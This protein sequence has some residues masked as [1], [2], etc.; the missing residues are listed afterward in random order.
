MVAAHRPCIHR[1]ICTVKP[2]Q[3]F[4]QL[5]H[6]RAVGI[7]PL[8]HQRKQRMGSGGVSSGRK[9][10]VDADPAAVEF[11]RRVVQKMDARRRSVLYSNTISLREK[12]EGRPCRPLIGSVC[13]MTGLLQSQK[14]LQ[15]QAAGPDGQSIL[16]AH[17]PPVPGLV[18]HAG[19]GLPVLRP[20]QDKPILSSIGVQPG[21][22]PVLCKAC[23]RIFVLQ[24]EISA[25]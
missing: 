18:G 15:G 5:G 4:A 3:L 8:Q 1:Q 17:I 20:A 2:R 9:S 16:P 22:S 25:A 24:R 12:N 13:G 7:A 6:I 21:K 23:I 10:K 11:G 14:L 19:G